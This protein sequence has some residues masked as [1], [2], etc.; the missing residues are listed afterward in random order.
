MEHASQQLQ[1]VEQQSL[2]QPSRFFRDQG[3]SN[4][5][6]QHTLQVQQSP[7][8]AAHPAKNPRLPGFGG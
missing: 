6:A 5:S 2:H 7:I 4:S 8:A 1:S 3:P